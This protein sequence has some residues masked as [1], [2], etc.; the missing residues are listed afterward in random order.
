MS[1]PS[2]ITSTADPAARTRNLQVSCRQIV[3][4]DF[5]AIADLLHI[6][7]PHRTKL[8]WEEGLRRLA[9]YTRPEGGPKFGYLLASGGAPVGV[10]LLISSNNGD[11][12]TPRIRSNL[13]SWYVRPE[14][15]AY[16]SLLSLRAISNRA[17]TYINVW[18]AENTLPTIKAQGFTKGAGGCFV[19]LPALNRFRRDVKIWS[20]AE[21]WNRSKFISPA[22]SRLLSDH[23]RFGCIC[24]WCE[25]NTEGRPFIF[26]RRWSRRVPVP[27]AMLI[28]SRSLDDLK[29][30]AGPIGRVLAWRGLPVILVGSDT[31][32]EGIIGMH[33]PDKLP[34][35]FKGP[36]RPRGGDLSYTDAALFGI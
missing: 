16:A 8:Y 26:K 3:I 12:A 15:R 35:Y 27:C 5:P 22:E 28:Y 14:F 6:G 32:L 20:R 23:E 36:L 21:E 34:I 24:L 17:V 31:P 19:A 29:V 2:D 7:F 18:P 25:T 11:E 1:A 4:D 33:F 13:S 30:F 9:V 10:L